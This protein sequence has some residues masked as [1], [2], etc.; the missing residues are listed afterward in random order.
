MIGKYGPD[1]V[2]ARLIILSP[3]IL[4]HS[5]R[6]PVPS[7]PHPSISTLMIPIYR[8]T[9]SHQSHKL[10]VYTSDQ[11]PA[12]LRLYRPGLTGKD[13][14]IVVCNEFRMDLYALE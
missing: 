9:C 4:L 12:S 5:Q 14:N 7:H 2:I 1:A 6:L 11:H 3:T 13:I 10:W 8:D